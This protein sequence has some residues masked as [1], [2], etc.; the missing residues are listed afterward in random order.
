VRLPAWLARAGRRPNLPMS[1]RAASPAY[2][3]PSV[4]VPS[5]TLRVGTRQPGRFAVDFPLI[6]GRIKCKLSRDLQFASHRERIARR[7]FGGNVSVPGDE[8][9]FNLKRSA[10]DQYLAVPHVSLLLFANANA[11]RSRVDYLLH[12]F[13]FYAALPIAA[14]SLLLAARGAHSRSGR[15]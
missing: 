14:V 13:P 5:F 2:G 9:H 7:D 6:I 15:G 4:M 3:A 1:G 11:E 12:L 8:L 10:F